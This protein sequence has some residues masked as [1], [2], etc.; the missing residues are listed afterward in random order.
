MSGGMELSATAARINELCARGGEIYLHKPS[1]VRYRIAYSAGEFHEL[2]PIS[3]TCRY[4]TD[5]Q[6]ADSEVWEKKP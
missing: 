4:A 6:L 2:H 3:G 1:G 5:D